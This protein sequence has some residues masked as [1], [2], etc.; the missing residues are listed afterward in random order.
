MDLSEDQVL[1][2]TGAG[3]ALPPESIVPGF[4][5][6]TSDLATALPDEPEVSAAIEV[7]T[8]A[9]IAEVPDL[10]DPF[11]PRRPGETDTNPLFEG[12]AD[13]LEDFSAGSPLDV[14]ESP[15][16]LGN[17]GAIDLGNDPI[18]PDFSLSF[19]A[20][21]P[22]IV[23]P[24]EAA[25]VIPTPNLVTE[26]ATARPEPTVSDISPL[27]EQRIQETLEKVAWEAFSD[28][29]ETIV[30]QVMDRVEKIAWEVIP[31]M[32]ETLVREE[33][34]KLKGEDD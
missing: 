29:S 10:P 20:P 17:A 6:S 31:E 7:P 5:V 4:D 21:A 30:K 18:D 34:R 25:P 28:L 12:E 11:Q 14:F 3:P 15:S 22:P 23:E 27:M 19:R 9:P 26:P 33:I 24:Q 2:G 8:F 16:E 13:L 1:S 32:A